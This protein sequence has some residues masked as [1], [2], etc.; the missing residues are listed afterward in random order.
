MFDA[1]RR[2]DYQST[3]DVGDRLERIR[4]VFDLDSVNQIPSLEEY[5]ENSSWAYRFFYDKYGYM[6]LGLSNW[7]ENPSGP[8][9]C[10][11]F[12]S[13]FIKK[14]HV[15]SVLELGF[16]V[17][18][19]LSYLSRR[20]P[21]VRFIGID[22]AN[23]PL[24]ANMDQK[25]VDFVQGDYH[26]VDKL[27]TCK[28]DLVF[29]VEALCYSSKLEVVKKIA[30]II[31]S[32]GTLIVLDIYDCCCPV[33]EAE[34]RARRVCARSVG[35]DSFTDHDLAEGIFSEQFKIVQSIDLSKHVM[36]SLERMET[37]AA[38]YF[39]HPYCARIFNKFYPQ[40]FAKNA[41]LGLLLPACFRNRTVCYHLDVVMLK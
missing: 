10:L 11:E 9:A 23:H 40:T 32:D 36:D 16:G 14:N 8:E 12:I 4:R 24:D 7:D 30:N 38:F 1:W 2:V 39:R 5:Y 25:N 21:D 41:I 35:I 15:G 34:Q 6:H 28:F 26:D 17:G 27:V 20:H 13:Q 31:K 19:N 18:S 3:T 22:R 33:T 37:V 29:A